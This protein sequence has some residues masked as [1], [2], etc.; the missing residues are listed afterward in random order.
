[1]NYEERLKKHENAKNAL[2][3]EFD[4]YYSESM[5]KHLLRVSI[6]FGTPNEV[7]LMSNR[8]ILDNCDVLMLVDAEVLERWIEFNEP[9]EGSIGKSS[10]RK[11]QYEMSFVVRNDDL[12]EEVANLIEEENWA[13][14]QKIF[15][16]K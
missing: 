8:Y 9:R 16:G 6:G 3:W 2:K 10:Y 11:I 4:G 13:E 1:M 7:L 15:G 5:D 12:A 14:I